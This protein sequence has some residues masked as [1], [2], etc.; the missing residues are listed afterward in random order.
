MPYVKYDDESYTVFK[1]SDSGSYAMRF[2]L[3]DKDGKTTPQIRIGLRTRDEAEAHKRAAKEYLNAQV[4]LE[5]NILTGPASFKNVAKDYLKY[6]ES[7]IG[8][9]PK[10]R[11]AYKHAKSTIDRFFIPKFGEQPVTMPFEEKF[12]DYVQWRIDYWTKGPGSKKPKE[13]PTYL[14]NGKE[15]KHK[16]V[17]KRA[18]KSTLKREN[19][20][21]RSVFNH[22]VRKGLIRKG[23]IPKLELPKFEQSKRPAFTKEQYHRV[24]KIAEQ[25]LFEAVN[26]PLTQSNPK[27]MEEEQAQKRREIYEHYQLFNFVEFAVETGMR[28]VELFNLNWGH[29][30]GLEIAR[31]APAS[32]RKLVISAFGKG[33]KLQRFVPRRSAIGNLLNLWD[34]AVQH[35]GMEP[36][37]GDAVFR[38][39]LGRRLKSLNRPL[40]KLLKE[41]DAL[42]SIGEDQNNG[43]KL[44]TYS[45]RHS[46]A[47]WQLE[48][49]PPIDV[50]TLAINMR[51]SVEM[52]E[53]WYS[54]ANV[55]S[56]SDILLGDDEW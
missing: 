1:R 27:E 18:S 11:S 47:T 52:I 56:Q 26:K 31:Q 51:T 20:F 35:F 55:V 36:K 45:F 7:Q 13:E 30:E 6:L 22:A 5:N 46:Y 15:V 28:P 37:K 8:D 48:K 33:K 12:E 25:R 50:Y 32:E 43:Q 17:K 38:D 39:Y 10:K 9:D 40:N 16:L 42:Y 21:L 54:K 3:V 29:L 24:L 49:N 4:R 53:K 34:G 19:S 14:R 2:T 41:A 23:D 44:S